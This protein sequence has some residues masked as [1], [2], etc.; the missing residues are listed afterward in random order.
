[1]ADDLSH[2]AR[3]LG[4]HI[5][6]AKREIDRRIGKTDRPMI[7]PYR[8]WG[9]ATEAFV[10][11]RVML[12]PGLSRA[13]VNDLWIR[14]LLNTYKRAESD[15][16]AGAQVRL[17]GL[18][19]S[20]EARSDEEGFI[21][22]TLAVRQNSDALWQPVELELISPCGPSGECATASAQVIIPS[23]DAQYGVISDLDDTVIRTDVTNVVR[24]VRAVAFSNAH[25]RL[26]FHGVAAFYRALHYGTAGRPTNPIFYVSSSPWNLYD[27]LEEFM[28]VR[29]IPAGP[30]VLRDWGL[31][32]NPSRNASHKVEA[33]RRIIDFYPKLPWILIGDSGQEDPEIYREI[34]AAYPDR[35]RAAY[36]RNV[37]PMPERSAKIKK[38]IEEVAASGATMVLTD[39]TMSAARHALEQG[40]I[41]PDAIRAI[42]RDEVLEDKKEPASEEE[43]GPTVVV[44]GEDSKS[45]PHRG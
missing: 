12:D 14:N 8:G 4:K 11:A 6:R 1:M 32:V 29:G 25:T 22:A 38:L 33:I 17:E 40:W 7:A 13:T 30:M 27:L 41:N 21:K 42:A 5:A 18:G 16:L 26:P 24:M 43:A 3:S 45:T 36:I 28:A 23:D 44:E 19:S 34:I 37:T 39:D 10:I 35:I 9:N 2:F 15:E 31:G 20:L